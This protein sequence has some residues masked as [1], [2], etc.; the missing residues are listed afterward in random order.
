MADSNGNSSAVP[1]WVRTVAF[2]IK[3]IGFPVVVAGTLIGVLVGRIDSP[4][5]VIGP[6]R[7]VLVQHNA[8]MST[9][10]ERVA[11]LLN[12]LVQASRGSTEESQ[13]LRCFLALPPDHRLVTWAL[14]A[15]CEYVDRLANTAKP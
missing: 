8:A 14:H 15:P 6:M 10:S 4:L 2:L 13:K 3:D 11:T 7:D 1:S 9:Q 5:T 12:D